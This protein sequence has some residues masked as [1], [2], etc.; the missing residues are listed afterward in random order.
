MSCIVVLLE[1]EG[2]ST[3]SRAILAYMLSASNV[4]LMFLA[5]CNADPF[6]HCPARDHGPLQY[7]RDDGR[8]A[9]R[10]VMLTLRVMIGPSIKYHRQSSLY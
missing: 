3:G 5:A 1:V 9:R 7:L 6:V 10:C 4:T 2:G 8:G